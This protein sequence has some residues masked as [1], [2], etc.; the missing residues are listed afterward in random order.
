MHTEKYISLVE[1]SKKLQKEIPK[2]LNKY[3]IYKF[4]HSLIHNGLYKTNLTISIFVK[5][6]IKIVSM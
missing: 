2:D 6:F 3:N 4:I 1:K 5:F